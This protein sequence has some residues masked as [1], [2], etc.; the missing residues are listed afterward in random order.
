MNDK[1]IRAIGVYP[2]LKK[3]ISLELTHET[4]QFEVKSY[5]ARQWDSFFNVLCP[6]I[7][8]LAEGCDVDVSLA[9]LRA[10]R[11]TS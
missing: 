3:Y 2:N 9:K 5:T 1:L 7:E 6:F 10:E 11:R 4:L 8:V